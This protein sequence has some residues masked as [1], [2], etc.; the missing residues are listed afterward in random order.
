MTV[1]SFKGLRLFTR[2]MCIDQYLSSYNEAVLTIVCYFVMK[3]Y[4]SLDESGEI[5]DVLIRVRPNLV[6]TDERQSQTVD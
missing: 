6:L 3:L 2:R 4:S 5:I 1:A